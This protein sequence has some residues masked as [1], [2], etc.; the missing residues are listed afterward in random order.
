[1]PWV[2]VCLSHF[3]LYD[4]R[5]MAQSADPMDFIG[6]FL[7]LKKSNVVCHSGISRMCHCGVA[8]NERDPDSPH[9][10]HVGEKLRAR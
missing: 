4:S 6:E 8:L 10:L 3:L 5:K 1:M 9:H 2:S 7:F